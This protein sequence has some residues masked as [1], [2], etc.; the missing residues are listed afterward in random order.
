MVVSRLPLPLRTSTGF[1]DH[2]SRE[3]GR[4]GGER[5]RERREKKKKGGGR[6]SVIAPSENLFRHASAVLDESSQAERR[7]KTKET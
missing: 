2:R 7:K 3:K 5:K 4:K 1:L 6:G